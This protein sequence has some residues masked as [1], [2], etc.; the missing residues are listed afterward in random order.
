LSRAVIEDVAAVRNGRSNASLMRRTL[1]CPNPGRE[2]SW[3]DVAV[4]ILA[5]LC[6]LEI[7]RP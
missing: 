4:A 5:K 1:T 7:S 2:E 6:A 3:S